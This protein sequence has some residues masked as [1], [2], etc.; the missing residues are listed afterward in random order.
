MAQK[1]E[2]TKTCTKC[3]IEQ[4]KDCFYH[5]A[6]YAGGLHSWCK[7]CVKANA[8]QWNKD[9][10]DRHNAINREWYVRQKKGAE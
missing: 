1:N 7:A 9:N 3:G 2:Q 5:N 10:K 4:K 6:A 8:K